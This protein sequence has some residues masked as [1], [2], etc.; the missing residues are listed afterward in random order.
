MEIELSFASPEKLETE[1]LVVPVCER[2]KGAKG[3]DGLGSRAKS[4]DQALG[5]LLQKLLDSGEVKGKLLETSLLHLPL[6]SSGGL[7]AKRLLLLG[8]GPRDKFSAFELRK[9]AGTAIRFLKAKS[10][11]SCAF[12]LEDFCGNETGDETSASR[13][14]VEG[15]IAGNFETNKYKSEKDSNE[16][17]AVTLAGV[18]KKN[19][20][21]LQATTREAKIVA[22]SQDFTR[23]LV[24]EP[25]NLLTPAILAER[26]RRMA[27]EVGLECEILDKQK[28]TELKMGAFLSVSLGSDEPPCMIVLRYLPAQAPPSPVLGL[29]GKGI[30]FDS[31]GI[32]IKPAADMDK[33]KYDMA[34]GAAMLGVIRA[35]ALLKPN[36]RVIAVVPA[37]ENLLGGKAQKPGD[38]QTSM[39]G[40]T[41][42]VLNT[43]AEGRLVLADALTY[44]HQVLGCT[45]LIDAATLTGACAVALGSV[46]AGVF[47][48]DD[49]L[50]ERL[51]ASSRTAGEKMWRLPLDDEYKEQL[52]SAFADLPNIGG[53]YGGAITAA[54][55]L[56]EFTAD[57]PW[58]HLDIAGTAWLDD[59]KPHMSKGPTGVAVRTLTQLVLDFAGQS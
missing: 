16:M 4:L 58:T 7:G 32:S 56:K 19:E 10:I 18:S 6:Y 24:N 59:N 54:H 22:E 41:I 55:F 29:I 38:I 45:H 21:A 52:R 8:C 26:A 35:V 9:V 48:S 1:A 47:G 25:G 34:G 51:L 36:V 53:R 23:D 33:M 31:G 43:D 40:K 46:N 2:K 30:T 49:S 50:V 37:S 12:L 28:I 39:S 13:A 5:G 11:S 27:A 14:V 44:A 20:P 3:Q 57:L 15:S 42:E 17:A